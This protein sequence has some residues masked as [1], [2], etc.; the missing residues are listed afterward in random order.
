LWQEEESI[1]L[2]ITQTR[3][4]NTQNPQMENYNEIKKIKAVPKTH[5]SDL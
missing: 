4:I 3:W 2:V 5:G 1:L